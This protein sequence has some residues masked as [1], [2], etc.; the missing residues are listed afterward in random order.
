[1]EIWILTSFFTYAALWLSSLSSVPA[2]WSEENPRQKQAFYSDHT[3]K[4]QSWAG[5]FQA[6]ILISGTW[7]KSALLRITSIQ[8]KV[9]AGLAEAKGKLTSAAV[10]ML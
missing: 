8:D 9:L 3:E 4:I 2:G 6:W 1:M 5:N 10:Q 7:V